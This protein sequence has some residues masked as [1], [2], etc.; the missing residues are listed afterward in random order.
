[1]RFG[2]LSVR[3]LNTKVLAFVFISLATFIKAQL[4]NPGFETWTQNL[5]VPSAMSPNAGNNTTGWWDYNHFNNSVLGSSP[6]SVRRVTDTVHGG[7]YAARLQTRVYTPASWNIY[8]TWGIPFIGHNYLDTLGIIYSGNVNVT[9]STFYPGIPCTQKVSQF[10]FYYQY[11]PNGNDTAE[12]RVMLVNQR[13]PVAGGW[14]KTNVAT[15][16]SGWQQA[17]VNLTYVSAL[18]PDTMWVLFSSSSLDRVPKP[19]SIFWL[20][21]MSITLL[22]GVDEMKAEEN[23][24]NIFPNPASEFINIQSEE[25]NDKV[26]LTEIYS[27]LG[28]KIKWD[29]Y[30]DELSFKINVSN[31]PKGIYYVKVYYPDKVISKKVVIE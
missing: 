25:K 22:S 31:F 4:I 19:G 5:L 7:S 16:A 17:T 15:G 2:N 14:F 18:T 24:I 21:D 27:T 20:D 13:N 23:K 6:I 11:K 8:K 29:G 12:C 3:T 10:K 1:M 26:L 30:P 28:E 9:N